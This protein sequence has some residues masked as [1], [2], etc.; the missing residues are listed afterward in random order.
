MRDRRAFF[1]ACCFAATA[2]SL[3]L[4]GCSSSESKAREAYAEYQAA[5]AAGDLNAAKIALLHLVSAQ[6]DVADNW[7]ELG[8]VQLQLGAYQDSYYAYTRAHELDRTDVDTVATLAQLALLS[9]NMDMA[10]EHA[11]N[12]ELLRPDHPVIK[13]AYGYVALKRNDLDAA[14]RNADALLALYPF[15]PG[16]TLLKSRIFAARGEFDKATA[17]LE[18]QAKAKP[19]DAGALKS[20]TI[21]YQRS[22]N[23]AGVA[24][25][26]ERLWRLRPDTENGLTVVNATLRANQIDAA[27]Q[28]SQ[29]LLRPDAPPSQVESVLNLWADHWK[30]PAAIAQA[31]RLASAANPNQQLA[32]AGYFNDVGSA[33][34]ALALAGERPVMPLKR[35]NL[36]RN[37]LIAGALAQSGKTAE[38]KQLFDAILVQEPDHVYALRGRINLEIGTGQAKAAIVDAQ[39][40]VSIEPKSDRDRL[41]LARAYAAA[42]NEREVDRTLWNAFHEIPANL[43]LYEALRARVLKSNGPDAAHALDEEFS[44]Q[45]DVSVA[46]EFI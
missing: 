32:Y 6:D 7:R 30:S 42:G 10:E 31:R 35:W 9:G 15:E 36:S 39:R 26:A 14:D 45:R 40:L 13:L 17:V 12:L 33:A 11:K 24:S 22:G 37:A 46:R 4:T 19:D 1:A 27:L 16:A 44:Q 2:I 5:S 41:L 34:D 20:L 3:T 29:E 23:W 21:L 25:A 8:K 38:A 28:A 18:A 43:Q